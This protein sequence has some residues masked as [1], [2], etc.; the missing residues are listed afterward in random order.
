MEHVL[1]EDED[2]F[3]SPKRPLLI[4]LITDNAQEVCYFSNTPSSQ[5]FISKEGTNRNK[6]D[7]NEGRGE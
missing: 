3:Q 6:K 4:N 1:P 2:R 7:K 5:T